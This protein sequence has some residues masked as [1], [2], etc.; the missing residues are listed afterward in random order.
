MIHSSWPPHQCSETLT[1]EFCHH[2]FTF[3]S[4]GHASL[5]TNLFHFMLRKML[6]FLSL[7]IIS[8]FVL[9]NI[10]R[11]A[12]VEIVAMILINLWH[13]RFLISCRFLQKKKF[14]SFEVNLKYQTKLDWI[15]QKFCEFLSAE[16]VETFLEQLIK[17]SQ[18]FSLE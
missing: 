2:S 18:T 16:K 4:T 13:K 12:Q 3:L 9:S 5:A 11:S 8:F 6:L 7:Q 1:P 10:N 17:T 14:L 15:W